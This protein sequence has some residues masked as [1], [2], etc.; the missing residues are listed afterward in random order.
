MATNSETLATILEA[1]ELGLSYLADAQA[2]QESGVS[3]GIYDPEYGKEITARQDE[4][5]ALI[6]RAID[7]VKAMRAASSD[8][9]TI[10]IS[11]EGGMVREV[12]SPDPAGLRYAVIDY[13]CSDADAEDLHAVQ[14]D[15]GSWAKA[16]SHGG[17]VARA[18]A[19]LV[20]PHPE[21]ADYRGALISISFCDD[22][23]EE[24]SAS[25]TVPTPDPALGRELALGAFRAIY[26]DATRVDA[27]AYAPGGAA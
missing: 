26:P 22:E 9:R 20:L 14:Q 1:L 7:A 17:E 10:W 5:E 4:Q 15:D 21:H 25:F 18:P 11:V 12:W 19:R 23:G 3:E 8:E 6:G 16:V 13:D 2:D 24:D 27:K